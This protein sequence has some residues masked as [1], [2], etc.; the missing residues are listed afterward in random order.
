MR[1]C[2]VVRSH[3]PP[4]DPV[5]IQIYF[6]LQCYWPYLLVTKKRYA[7]LMF[8]NPN[9]PDYID[10]KGLQLVRR[11]SCPLVKHVSTAILDEIMYQRSAIGAVAKAREHI[12]RILRNEE[13]LDSFLLS[14]KLKS[15]YANE[16]AQ[17]HVQVARK[18]RDRTGSLIPSGA[19]VPFV[20]VQDPRN[21][22]GKV[23]ERAEDPGYVRDNNEVKLDVLYYIENQLETP[24]LTLLK[25]LV[26]DPYAEVFEW[27]TIKDLL[28]VMRATRKGM[29]EDAKRVRT[30]AKRGL[31]P[32]TDFFK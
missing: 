8:T 12:L 10:V 20:I 23:A 22:D 31:R 30:N 17:P 27:S 4:H 5:V 16:S 18:I 7:G 9:K 3:R 6:E 14:K 26:D 19:R 32:I 29:I 2:R 25:L 1:S 28:T 11:D 13:P 15:E 24:I 21:P